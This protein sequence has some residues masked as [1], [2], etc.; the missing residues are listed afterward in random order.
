MNKM[1]MFKHKVDKSVL[2]S[3]MFSL[4]YYK[5]FSIFRTQ[6]I[7]ETVHFVFHIA[8]KLN[9]G[10]AENRKPYYLVPNPSPSQ[11]STAL[12]SKDTESNG[13]Q[14]EKEYCGLVK[15]VKKDNITINNI[16]E[17]MLCQ[18]PGVS[19]ATAMAVFQQFKNMASLISA[20]K[21]NPE[22]LQDLSYTNSKGQTRK[23]SKTA[24]ENI[25]KFMQ[26]SE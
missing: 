7:E 13:I 18:I 19:S 21:E 2:Y 10:I 1:I 3:A 25:K 23:I 9:K 17:I 14:E 20:L 15:R 6:N 26:T 24:I 5:G 12:G 22:C 16:G 11:P 8:N 4:N